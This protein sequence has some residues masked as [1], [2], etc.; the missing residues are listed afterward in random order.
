MFSC[1]RSC[2]LYAAQVG[3]NFGANG[4]NPVVLLSCGA[5]DS[6]LQGGSKF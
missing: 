6:A 5:V 3:S 4:Q 2:L 1:A